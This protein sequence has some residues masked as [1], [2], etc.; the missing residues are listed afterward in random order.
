MG[1]EFGRDRL[2]R[3]QAETAEAWPPLAESVVSLTVGGPV[4]AGLSQMRGDDG[5]WHR[6]EWVSREHYVAFCGAKVAMAHVRTRVD[7]EPTCPNPR[8]AP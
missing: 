3:H 7:G 6:F 8:C 2:P 5:T 1:L 4:E